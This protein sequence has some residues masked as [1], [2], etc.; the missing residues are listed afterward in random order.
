[1]LQQARIF[2][3]V[4]QI[5]QQMPT[6]LRKQLVVIFAHTHRPSIARDRHGRLFVNPGEV[7]GWMFRRPT[8]AVYDTETREAEI[9]NL[10]AMPPAVEIEQWG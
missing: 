9:V 7:G 10:P 6:I 4:L 2:L 1:M 3:T 8:V 5:F